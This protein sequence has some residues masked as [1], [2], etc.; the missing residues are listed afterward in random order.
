MPYDR[1]P[2][3]GSRRDAEEQVGADR[4]DLFM[5]LSPREKE[6]IYRRA[7]HPA[8]P[9]LETL[10]AYRRE[11]ARLGEGEQPVSRNNDATPP[12]GDRRSFSLCATHFVNETCFGEGRI[13]RLDTNAN[14]GAILDGIDEGEEKYWKAAVVKEAR[15]DS[16]RDF[17]GVLDA[18]YNYHLCDQLG[19]DHTD[20]PSY[21]T[22][23]RHWDYDDHVL[24]AIEELGVRARYAGLWVGVDFPPDLQEEG[25][26]VDLILEQDPKLN[27]K[28]ICMRHL[29]E[30]ALGVMWP[31]LSFGRDP[32]E[33]A[34]KLSPA[35]FVSLFSHL[36]LEQSYLETG[37]RTLEWL[38]FPAPL[39]SSSTT[40]Q[41]IS[42]LDVEKVDQMLECATA[43]LLLQEQDTPVYVDPTEADI[44]PPVHLAYDT[45]K[46][47]W[48][49]DSSAEWTSKTLPRNNSS[50]AWVFGILS[51]VSENTA[52]VLGALPLR[53]QT[54]IGN[55]LR[56]FLRRVQGVYDLE[57]GRVYLDSELYTTQ[58]LNA[59][60]SNDVDFLIRAKDTGEVSD[61]LDDA[62]DGDP[63]AR[64]NVSFGD[65]S[66]NR[67]PDAF[68]WPIPEEETGSAGRDRDH[69]AFLTDMDLDDRD[70]E[71][72]G[73]KFRDRWGVETAIRE[74]KNRYHARCNSPNPTVRAFYFMMATVL[75]NVSQYV[76]NRLDERLRAEDVKWS[77]EELLHV[78][79]EIDPDAV[80]DWGDAFDPDDGDNWVGLR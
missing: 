77:G 23:A 34:F 4:R 46:I 11:L 40:R 26:G 19:F 44:E 5:S 59:L 51:I 15:G 39:P 12:D 72:L 27:E 32:D 58:A 64:T 20:P 52:Y 55:Y 53:S 60:R 66:L 79:R 47:R 3:W 67:R 38:D 25:W 36:A 71:T 43:A 35:S 24:D 42:E 28:M 56:R 70:L 30:E 54:E 78:T 68:A 14:L 2:T 7:P 31:H 13:P 37:R 8:V 29:V 65:L 57:I 73:R 80:P 16:L 1:D 75:Y 48:Y 61:L 10:R 49:G 22:L 21:S 69:V 45:T 50:S 74:I 33:P 9:P 62:D 76:D 17:E 6:R 63:K 41:Y 18:G